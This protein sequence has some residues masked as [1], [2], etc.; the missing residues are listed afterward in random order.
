LGIQPL[1]PSLRSWLYPRWEA[2]EE[3]TMTFVQYGVILQFSTESYGRIF[4]AKC[5][6]LQS[7]NSL[8]HEPTR[9]L[10]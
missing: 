6:L 5:W 4:A 7:V 9:S 10:T 1:V 3:L 8:V 2:S